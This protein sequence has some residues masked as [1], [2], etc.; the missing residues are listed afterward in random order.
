MKGALTISMPS[1]VAKKLTEY[2]YKP[3]KYQQY[4]PYEPNPI[5]YGKNSDKIVHEKESPPLNE[6]EKKFVQQVL[7]SFL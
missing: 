5:I 6:N 3:Y 2:G 4:C 1:Y 7:G